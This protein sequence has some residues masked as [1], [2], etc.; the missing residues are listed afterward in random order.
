MA[1]SITTIEITPDAHVT[2]R[3]ETQD[4]RLDS[5]ARQDR[6][7]QPQSHVTL[8]LVVGDATAA[9]PVRADF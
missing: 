4:S 5:G 8:P 9:T 7:A 6:L 1:V 2:I 3:R